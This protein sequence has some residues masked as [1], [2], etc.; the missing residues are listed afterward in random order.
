M[1][2]R[3]RVSEFRS[4]IASKANLLEVLVSSIVNATRGM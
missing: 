2:V 4:P 3:S 1:Y